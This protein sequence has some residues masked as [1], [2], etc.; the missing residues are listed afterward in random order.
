MGQFAERLDLVWLS[1]QIADGA[2]VGA[3]GSI[4]AI[5]MKW[6]AIR[7]TSADGMLR[8]RARVSKMAESNKGTGAEPNKGPAPKKF[9]NFR[10]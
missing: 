10:D 1:D 2:P 9:I 3:K 5:S 6:P 4:H 8:E 7:D